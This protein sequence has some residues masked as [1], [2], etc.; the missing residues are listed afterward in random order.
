MGNGGVR[1][2]VKGGRE[3]EKIHFPSWSHSEKGR[4]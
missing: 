2:E 1:R 4:L 3:G